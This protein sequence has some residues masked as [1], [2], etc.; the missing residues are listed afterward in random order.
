MAAEDS[1]TVD[2]DTYVRGTTDLEAYLRSQLSKRILIIDGAM[3]TMIQKHKLVEEDYRGERFADHDTNLRGNNDILNLTK[4]DIIRGIHKEYLM[5]GADIVETNTFN[6]TSISQGDYNTVCTWECLCRMV[7]G[8]VAPL[9]LICCHP[10]DVCCPSA[11]VREINVAAARL[12]R[13]AADE[14]TALDPSRPR[15]VAGALG[16][17]NVTASLSPDVE[18]ASLRKVTFDQ[19]VT[20]YLEEARALLEGGVDLF[21]VETIFD[22]LNAKVGAGLRGVLCV[23]HK[24]LTHS[25]PGPCHCTGCPV[26][27]RHFV[28]GDRPQAAAVRVRH[29]CGQQRPHAVRSDDRGVLRLH[30][31]Q[32]A[33]GCRPQ[34]CPWCRADAS[35]HYPPCEDRGLLRVLLPERRPAERHGR[36]RR[37]ARDHGLAGCI[38]RRGWPPEH[39]WWL[40]RL[41]ATPHRGDREGDGIPQAAHLD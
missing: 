27:T 16:P 21:F 17:T 10:R 30:C 1:K 26:R 2:V 25:L 15:F 41:D 32:Q 36:L 3:G 29:H 9:V 13:E 11:L 18:D 33:V 31:P 8:S 4:P 14:V 35:L 23:L 7:R 20:A 37:F 19:L 24:A 39:G 38:V 28:R 5:A 34:L 22:T 6:G 40:L 12:A